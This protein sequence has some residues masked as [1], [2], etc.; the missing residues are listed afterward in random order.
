MKSFN[1]WYKFRENEDDQN[2]DSLNPTDSGNG[3]A[4]FRMIRLAWKSHNAE[5]QHFF[6]KLAA[7]DPEIAGEYQRIDGENLDMPGKIK[8]SDKDEIRPPSSDTG[9]GLNDDQD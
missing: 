9:P 1:E 5:T 6:K 3:S 2:N 8:D 4:L 7:I